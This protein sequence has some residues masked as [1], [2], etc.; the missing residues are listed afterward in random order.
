MKNRII[1]VF[2]ALLALFLFS[3]VAHAVPI[4]GLGILGDSRADEYRADDNRGGAY[5]VTTLNWVELLQK[6]RGVNLGS[7]G[8]R[9]YPRRTGYEFNWGLSGEV[10][11]TMVANGQH[12]GLAAQVQAGLV[13]HVILDIGANDFSNLNGTY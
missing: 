1:T 4:T 6:Y 12:T 9:A 2:R 13:S 7:W 8:T 5:A 11:A 10:T 3:S